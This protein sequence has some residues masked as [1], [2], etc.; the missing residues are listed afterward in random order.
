M[1]K[2]IAS[3]LDDTLLELDGTIS[4]ENKRM[5]K[6]A[7]DEGV[8]FTI[9]TGRM[10][11]SAARYGLELGLSPKQ[12]IICYNGALIKRLSGETLYEQP[13]AVDV[14]T[15]FVSYGQE[16]KW[17]INA[18]YN[19]ELYVSRLDEKIEEYANFTGVG[20]REVGDLAAFIRDGDLSLSKLLVIGDPQ[21]I[22]AWGE[23]VKRLFQAKAQI[24]Q[25]R[26][27]FIEVTSPTAH[28]G[29]ALLWLAQF[30]G[31][32]QEEIM[33]IGDSHN[34]LTMV[35]MAGLGVAV[36]NARQT[37]KKA[38]HHITAA[39]TENGVA[40]AIEKFVLNVKEVV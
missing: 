20:V 13:L 1:I 22:P 7:L 6:K 11:T 32:K 12:P 23:E 30:F 36:A 29:K 28:K 40:R 15:S 37:V 33:A 19:D 9:A 2:L 31:F 26:A 35:Q 16:R 18:Y 25:S 38:A 27:K 21:K 5:I 17:S 39:H 3:D 34:D 14:A 10:F 8:I 4:A 24:T